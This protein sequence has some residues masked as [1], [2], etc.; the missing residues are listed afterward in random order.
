MVSFPGTEGFLKHYTAPCA[1][2]DVARLFLPPQIAC[3]V[4]FIFLPILAKRISVF[5]ILLALELRWGK[6]SSLHPRC[7]ESGVGEL[8]LMPGWCLPQ[9]AAPTSERSSESSLLG[10]LLGTNPRK[11]SLDALGWGRGGLVGFISDPK[12]AEG[13]GGGRRW[14]LSRSAGEG[15]AAW[16]PALRAGGDPNI[17]L[18]GT[19]FSPRP[20][21]RWRASLWERWEEGTRVLNWGNILRVAGE[22]SWKM[23]EVGE[24]AGLR[25]WGPEPGMIPTRG[26]GGGN[27]SRSRCGAG[28]C[29]GRAAGGAEPPQVQ[30]GRPARSPRSGCPDRH[31]HHS[32]GWKMSFFSSKR[33]WVSPSSRDGGRGKK[34]RE[35]RG[36]GAWEVVSA[37]S[38]SRGC[39]LPGFARS[40]ALCDFG[41]CFGSPSRAPRHPSAAP[42]HP[43]G[44]ETWI[45]L[46]REDIGRCSPCGPRCWDCPAHRTCERAPRCKTQH[47][48][49]DFQRRTA[50]LRTHSGVYHTGIARRAPH[51]QR[52]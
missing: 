16:K 24:D 47:H 51:L 15:R 34:E 8:W 46:C 35:G 45:P 12:R 9:R 48:L 20:L 39:A 32:L 6:E 21:K 14:F 28:G 11:A 4:L 10:G 37:A 26:R 30:P 2:W 49:A 33:W 5:K 52:A 17:R 31:H 22:Q 18:P 27:S 44:G 19:D 13:G 3:I 41:L 29:R 50:E 42:Q 7:I 36:E 40:G 43:R 38:P 1:S 25:G 23:L